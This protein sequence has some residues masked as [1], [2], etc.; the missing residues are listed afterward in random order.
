MESLGEEKS[1]EINQVKMYAGPSYIRE[2][3]IGIKDDTEE[4]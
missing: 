2:Y 4:A 1:I 3:T